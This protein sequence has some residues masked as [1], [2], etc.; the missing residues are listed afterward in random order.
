M[1]RLRLRCDGVTSLSPGKGPSSS[2]DFGV[3]APD[4]SHGGLWALAAGTVLGRCHLSKSA[5]RFKAPSRV[6]LNAAVIASQAGGSGDVSGRPA[7]SGGE[8]ELAR[9]IRQGPPGGRDGT[10]TEEITGKNTLQVGAV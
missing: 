7:S 8:S 1:P 9:F 10:L 4:C 2:H 3:R 5:S 6:E